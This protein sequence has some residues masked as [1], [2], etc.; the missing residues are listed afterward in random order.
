MGDRQ[1]TIVF[2]FDPRNPRITAFQVHEW[3]FEKLHLDEEDIRMI[4]IDGTRRQVFIKFTHSTLLH[5][6][7]TE[8]N[9]QQEFKHDNGELSQVTIELA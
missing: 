7:L 5:N 1:N 2:C 6:V 8:T 4:Q 9:G 3:I